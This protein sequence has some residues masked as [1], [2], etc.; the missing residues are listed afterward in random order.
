MRTLL[1][2][3]NVLRDSVLILAECVHFEA[4]VHVCSIM[5]RVAFKELRGLTNSKGLELSPI[6]LNVLYEYLYDLGSMLQ[7]DAFKFFLKTVIGHGPM[8]TRARG[9]LESSTQT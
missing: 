3:S 7:S 6:E 5:W 8:C 2:Q 4:Y 9:G 1:D